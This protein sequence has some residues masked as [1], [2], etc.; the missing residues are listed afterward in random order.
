MPFEAATPVTLNMALANRRTMEENAALLMGMKSAFQLS[1]D[2]VAHIGHVLSMTMNKT[3]AD[4]DGMSDALTYAAPVAKN[5]GVSIEET[6]AM[7][8]ALHDAKI[9]GSMADGKP[10]RVKPSAGTDGKSMGCTQRAWRENL[11]Q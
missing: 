11:R 10:C 8:G 2:K 4:F 6:A 7:V 1:N 3:A 9:T 5:A